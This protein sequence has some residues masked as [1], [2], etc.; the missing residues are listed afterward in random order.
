MN[1]RRTLALVC[2]AL[3]AASTTAHGQARLTEG[4]DAASIVNR[5]AVDGVVEAPRGGV[6][7]ILPGKS[8]TPRTGVVIR[9]TGDPSLPRPRFIFRGDV[10]G[11]VI[12]GRQRVTLDGIAI[13]ASGGGRH[14]GIQ[15]RSSS[16]VTLNDCRVLGWRNNITAQVNCR[17]ITVRGCLIE[18]SWAT[19]GA[20]HSQGIYAA[21]TTGLS[22][23]D[24]VFIGNGHADGTKT[25]TVFN[26][27]VYVNA[28]CGPV[29]VTSS[30][31]VNGGN[32]G[33]QQRSGG[34]ARDLVF[35][36]NPVA[37][38]FGHMR[39]GPA[40]PGGVSGT[41]DRI[42]AIGGRQ[43]VGLGGAFVFGNIKAVTATNLVAAH[44]VQREDSPYLVDVVTDATNPDQVVRVLD[45][46][47]SRLY[48]RDWPGRDGKALRINVSGGGITRDRVGIPL[49]N[50]TAD[51]R[52]A[53]GSDFAARCRANPATAARDA[54]ALLDRAA[55]FT[56]T[57][58]DPEPEPQPD[59]PEVI[60]MRARLVAIAT[61][62]TEI[63]AADQQA[64]VTQAQRDAERSALQAE[65]AA[66]V[67]RLP[68]H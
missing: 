6:W 49:P 1:T 45:L 57:T 65:R 66:I 23:A 53:L 55:G 9:A 20:G 43:M 48:V 27:N 61:R 29:S 64:V 59:S 36:N 2:I 18:N 24:S 35:L 67:A 38:S 44:D 16:N 62:L 31:F 13:E 22:I 33:L 42:Y 12:N 8:M 50:P 37:M 51:L 7:N 28:S 58:P 46:K 17:N 34:T 21:E 26:H 63:T 54:L 47:L 32:F 14:D 25:A 11:V 56:G 60:A 4:A 30:V 15:I 3:L 68:S 5:A 52:A 10:N 19:A 39:S 41:L 40:H